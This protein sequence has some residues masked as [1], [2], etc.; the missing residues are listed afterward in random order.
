MYFQAHL[1]FVCKF[2]WD[3]SSLIS[4][5]NISKYFPLFYVARKCA[6]LHTC[7]LNLLP[8]GASQARWNTINET[9]EQ[10]LQLLR[11]PTGQ[12]QTSWLFTALR[13]SSETQGQ[14]EGAGK[15]LGRR[16]VKNEEKSSSLRSWLFFAPSNCPWVSED[17]QK[18]E[19][20][21]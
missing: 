4:G 7:I 8:I 6:K 1:N 21:I 19:Y 12:K 17:D 18:R 2:P 3:N 11:I 16:K 10:Q 5:T 20:R 14:F 9:T 15:K 13:A